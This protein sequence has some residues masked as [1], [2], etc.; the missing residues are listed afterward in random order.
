[1]VVCVVEVVEE[2]FDVFLVRVRVLVEV[3]EVNFVG[4]RVCGE[5]G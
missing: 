2:L 1:M 3:E 5:I 4:S